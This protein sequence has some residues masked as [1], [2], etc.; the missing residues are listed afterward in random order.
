M[1]HGKGNLYPGL[2]LEGITMRSSRVFGLVAVPLLVSFVASPPD[3][4][5]QAT[6]AAPTPAEGTFDP[7]AEPETNPEDGSVYARIRHLE[8]AVSL[9]RDSQ[10]RDDLT[11]NEPVV[12]GDQIDTADGRAEIQFSDGTLLRLDKGTSLV[13]RSLSDNA[14]QIENSTILQLPAGSLIVRTDRIDSRMERFQIDTPAASVFVLSEGLFRVDVRADGPT[15]I[16]SRGGAAE[17]MAQDVSNIVRSGERSFVTAGQAPLEPQVYNTLRADAF[18]DWSSAR[19]EAL[20]YRE[21]AQTRIPPGLPDPVE[22]YAEEL[23]Y[24]GQWINTPSYGWVWRPV[25]VAQ[26]WRPYYHGRW[27][28]S[29]AGMVWASYEPWGWA[30]YHYGRWEFLVGGGWVWIPG[31]VYGGAHVA[32]LYSP[33]YFGWAPLGYYDYPVHIGF[34]FGFFYSPWVYV[35]GHHLYHHDI[36]TV[37]VKEKTVI[38]TIEKQYVVVPGSP[39]ISPDQVARRP[40]IA[41]EAHRRV[42]AR[43]ELQMDPARNGRQV[44]FHESERQQLARATS[45][46]VRGTGV[47]ARSVGRSGGRPVTI[48]P[49]DRGVTVPRTR[50]LVRSAAGARNGANPGNTRN[51]A[52]PGN[53]TTR[54][55]G[56]QVTTPQKAPGAS[57][58]RPV[59]QRKEPYMR[60]GS[61]PAEESVP[62]KVIPRIIPRGATG[63]NTSSPGGQDAAPAQPGAQ[64]APKGAAP[65]TKTPT[66]KQPKKVPSESEGEKPAEEKSSQS[67]GGPRA[68]RAT[69]GGS[70]ANTAVFAHRPAATSSMGS[71]GRVVNASRQVPS[72]HRGARVAAPAAGPTPQTG[73]PRSISRSSSRAPGSSGR[74]VNRPAAT[75]STASSGR[76]VSR[77]AATSSTGSSG[78]VVVSR[79]SAPVR[80]APVRSVSARSAPSK[81]PSSQGGG[82]KGAGK[83]P[84]SGRASRS[85][86]R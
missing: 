11:L 61:A 40:Q 15:V 75:S 82:S 70:R 35:H 28:W 27:V 77:P 59:P 7:Y 41:D 48:V 37:C 10:V 2:S 52:N 76:V 23:S 58:T 45:Q 19:D 57:T 22:P 67:S 72:V 16:A 50:T 64:T 33:G 42:A 55:P 3:A 29:P 5:P 4:L 30:P 18:D 32:W 38:H 6:P 60:P 51:G 65:R 1:G 26:D 81:A 8:G 62:R 73:L 85:Q 69:P 78:R 56:T 14:N 21:T 63:G 20:L 12:P 79:P 54:R 47:G 74:V 13:V 31:Y 43:R 25:G 49:Q 83:A 84:R 44:P 9:R 68:S 17:V 46:R 36:H 71:S 39:R 86:D 24:H 66:R 53:T 80:S 34:H